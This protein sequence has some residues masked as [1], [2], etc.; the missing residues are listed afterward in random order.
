MT[1]PAP[2]VTLADLKNN[3]SMDSQITYRDDWALR[4]SLDAAMAWVQE[5]RPELDYHGPW[6]VSPAVKLGT[7]LL[8]ARWFTR[9][10]SPDGLV[11]F[12]ELGTG[13]VPRIDGDIAML[14]GV[15]PT[16]A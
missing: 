4:R 11:N 5:Q 2:W 1:A 8:A 3:L 10:N 9:R 7:V 15:L 16:F 6:S 13:T 14:L 12:G